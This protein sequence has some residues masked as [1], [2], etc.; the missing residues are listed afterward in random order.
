MSLLLFFVCIQLVSDPI[1]PGMGTDDILQYDDGTAEWFS[2]EGIYRGTWFHL[3]DFY[4]IEGASRFVLNYAEIWFFHVYSQPW[5]TSDFIC[6]ITDGTPDVPGTVFDH[7]N[8]IASHLNP[9]MIYPFA[10]CTTSADFTVTELPVFSTYGAPSVASDLS[11]TTVGRSFS[12]VSPGN[13]DIW[14]FD[15]LI[16]VNGYPVPPVELSRVSWAFLK[17]TFY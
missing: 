3:D 4:T 1:E 9:S 12:V 11:P 6:E 10:P 15:Y 16:R 13:I 7:Q 8:S 2:F 5:D 14:Q 17:T